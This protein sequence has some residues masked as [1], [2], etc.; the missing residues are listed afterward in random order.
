MRRHPPSILSRPFPLPNRIL[1][2][3]ILLLRILLLLLHITLKETIS[4]ILSDIDNYDYRSRSH[5]R[6]NSRSY[7]RTSTGSGETWELYAEVVGAV[8]EVWGRMDSIL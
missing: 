3:R 2:L 6:T 7:Q 1:L 5:S 4:Q 8:F